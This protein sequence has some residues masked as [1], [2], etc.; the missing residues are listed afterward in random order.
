MSHPSRMGKSCFAMSC[1]RDEPSVLRFL[2]VTYES[3]L[4]AVIVDGSGYLGRQVCPQG[5]AGMVCGMATSMSVR[6]GFAGVNAI[7]STGYMLRER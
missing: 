4:S 5:M 2:L 6:L 3:V 7:T 1:E